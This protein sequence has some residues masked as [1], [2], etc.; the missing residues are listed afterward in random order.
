[1][2]LKLFL[3]LVGIFFSLIGVLHFAR[4][5][6][7]WEAII[8]GWAVPQ[9]ASVVGVIVAFYLVYTSLSLQKEN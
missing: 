4:L 2:K 8:A 1:M 3:K 5:V 7:G 6:F 9:W